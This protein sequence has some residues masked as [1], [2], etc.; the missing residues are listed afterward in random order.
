[1]IKVLSGNKAAA[2]GVRLARPDV[3]AM[4]PITPQT[5]LAEE[6]AKFHAEGQ[7]DSEMIEVEGEHSAMSAITGASVAGGRVFTATSSWGLSYMNEPFMYCAGMRVPA[8]MV[9]VTRETSSMRGVG[10][11]RQDIMTIRDSGWIQIEP[12]NCQEVLDS[13]LMAYR[14]SEDPDILLPVVVAYD[15]FFLSHQYER[16]EVPDQEL[17]DKFLEP[18][19]KKRRKRTTLEEGKNLHFSISI[20]GG[21][22]AKL[23]L[24]N[25]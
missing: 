8:V 6:L 2:H 13:I 10:G 16:V 23:S 21:D 7:I 5:P 9:D 19:S 22:F 24:S 11:S 4:Y 1:M 25:A 12:A 3:I 18:V 15:G 20:A 14:L 17:V